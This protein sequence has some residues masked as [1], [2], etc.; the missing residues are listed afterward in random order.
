MSQPLVSICTPTYNR[1]DLL[2]R[3]IRSCLAQ[4]YSNFEMIITDNSANELSGELAAR[5]ADPRIRYF[6]NETNLGGVGNISRATSLARGKYVKL[7]MD[8]DLLKSQCLEKMV[9]ALERNPSAGI[10][11]GGRSACVTFVSVDERPGPLRAGE[12]RIKSDASLGAV[13]PSGIW[14]GSPSTGPRSVGDRSPGGGD[15]SLIRA[16]SY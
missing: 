2:A 7:L 10:A 5:F 13:A 15:S 3:A 16:A 8:D 9:I 4:T 11:M 6:K 12:F 14:R 1:P